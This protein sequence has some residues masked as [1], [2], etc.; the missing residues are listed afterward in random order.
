[1]RFLVHAKVGNPGDH[2]VVQLDK[3]SR[4]EK[5]VDSFPRR[6]LSGRMLLIDTGLTAAETR[7]FPPPRDFVDPGPFPTGA[8]FI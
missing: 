3:R 2:Q 1:M 5:K 7:R 6:E 4:I 8:R